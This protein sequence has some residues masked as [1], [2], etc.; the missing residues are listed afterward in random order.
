MIRILQMKARTKGRN[1]ELFDEKNFHI[2]LDPR[3][4]FFRLSGA[5]LIK[6]AIVPCDDASMELPISTN[7]LDL[8]LFTNERHVS[9][10]FQY[11]AE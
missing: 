7:D 8:A 2:Q 3:H 10:L 1:T 11:I 6:D 4:K 9:E 5:A